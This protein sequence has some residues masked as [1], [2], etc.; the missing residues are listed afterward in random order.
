MQPLIQLI[1]AE[2]GYPGKKL[3]RVSLSI[4]PGEK[5]LL[6]GPNGAGKSTL[7]KTL[8]GS[9]SPLS[10]KQIMPQ[11]MAYVPQ[12]SQQDLQ[13]PVTLRSLV[14]AG[15]PGYAKRKDKDCLAKMQE[16][17]KEMGLSGTGEILLRE[18]SGGQLQRALLARAFIGKPS[19]VL[20]DEP[21]SSIDRAG[22]AEISF[23]IGK[24]LQ[25]TKAALLIIDHFGVMPKGFYDRHLEIDGGLLQE[26]D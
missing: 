20:M 7:A 1:D 9:Q 14:E 10:G 24:F 17:L 12:N 4:F 22:R 5:I 3:F 19:F 6:T 25:E 16:V 2:I 8:L 11:A 13:Y 21:F 18:A 15:C 23:L 26:T